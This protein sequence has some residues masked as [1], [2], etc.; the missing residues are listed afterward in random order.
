MKVNDLFKDL[1]KVSYTQESAL[2]KF[3][4]LGV[5]NSELRQGEAEDIDFFTSFNDLVLKPDTNIKVLSFTSNIL[6][7]IDV[8]N[9][10]KLLIETLDP[11]ASTLS[12]DSLECIDID[13]LLKKVQKSATIKLL[14]LVGNDRVLYN[15]V[16]YNIPAIPEQ[17]LDKAESLYSVFISEGPDVQ[18]NSEFME[19]WN[20]LKDTVSQD[21][22]YKCLQRLNGLLFE[23]PEIS[24]RVTRLQ[25]LLFV[26]SL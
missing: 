6:T 15:F 16:L 7:N 2:D 4:I 10:K 21:T 14:K 22:V 17:L 18:R 9:L 11:T 1:L 19:D 24:N 26:L 25:K 13:T 12:T 8:L 5:F 20:Y 3:P 23:V